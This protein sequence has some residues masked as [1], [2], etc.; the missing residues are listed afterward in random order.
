MAFSAIGVIIPS[1]Y[2]YLFFRIPKLH[3]SPGDIYFGMSIAELIYAAHLYYL[4]FNKGSLTYSA[5]IIAGIGL[6]NMPLYLCV[7]N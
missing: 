4:K 7:I 2:I 3:K 1:I 6:A 5:Y